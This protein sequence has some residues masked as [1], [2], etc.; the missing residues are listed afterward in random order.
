MN[1][2]QSLYIVYEYLMFPF[3]FIIA[4]KACYWASKTLWY[5]KLA[6]CF[7]TSKKWK[8]FLVQGWKGVNRLYCKTFTI[9]VNIF[10]TILKLLSSAWKK[11]FNP[12]KYFNVRFLFWTQSY[13]FNRITF[14][15]NLILACCWLHKK[16]FIMKRN[17]DTTFCRWKKFAVKCW[18]STKFEK[19][20]NKIVNDC[21][22]L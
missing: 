9:V 20:R 6:W 17:F 14:S 13:L 12:G 16:L 18:E 22:N 10:Q 8:Y 19:K 2:T 3:S 15:R 7:V 11:R 4:S 21:R 5:Y 1:F